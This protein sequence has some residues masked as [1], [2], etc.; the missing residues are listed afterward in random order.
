MIGKVHVYFGL[1][2]KNIKAGYQR[3]K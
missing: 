1:K 2:S 3:K